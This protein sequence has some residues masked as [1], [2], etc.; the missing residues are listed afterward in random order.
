[1]GPEVATSSVF[2]G[3]YYFETLQ[4][5]ILAGS[6]RRYFKL[7]VSTVGPSSHEYASQFGLANFFYVKTTKNRVLKRRVNCKLAQQ[8]RFVVQCMMLGASFCDPSSIVMAVV[9]I[10]HIFVYD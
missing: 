1:M 7:F 10:L 3:H 8:L 2:H 9:F 4:V 6:S 5:A